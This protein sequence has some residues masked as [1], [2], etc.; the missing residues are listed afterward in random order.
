MNG[1]LLKDFYW[2]LSEGDLCNS[3]KCKKRCE[4]LDR[5]KERR[6]LK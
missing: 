3:I 5:L 2:E 1:S 6:S 4:G